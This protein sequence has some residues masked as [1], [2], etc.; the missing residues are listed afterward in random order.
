MGG[1]KADSQRLDEPP[2]PMAAE[3]LARQDWDSLTLDMQHGMI[4]YSTA[5]AMLT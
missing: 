3:V 2:C 4:D 5:L 1:S